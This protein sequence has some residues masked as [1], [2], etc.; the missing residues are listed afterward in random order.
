VTEMSGQQ[1]DDLRQTL[2]YKMVGMAFAFR[3]LHALVP[4]TLGVTL[5]GSVAYGGDWLPHWVITAV[6]VILVL[7]ALLHVAVNR[8]WE[9]A[10]KNNKRRMLTRSLRA[11]PAT[12]PATD[13]VEGQPTLRIFRPD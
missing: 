7:D 10:G 6:A 13:T 9:S 1:L 8:L 5:I 11:A 12:T 2:T 3:K 4:V